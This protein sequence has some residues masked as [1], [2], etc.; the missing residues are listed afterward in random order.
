MK[1]IYSQRLK[2]ERIQT[3]IDDLLIFAPLDVS[4]IQYL[5]ND[6]V[7]LTVKSFDKDFIQKRVK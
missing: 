4:I 5:L 6:P 2:L 3:D 1:C 7:P